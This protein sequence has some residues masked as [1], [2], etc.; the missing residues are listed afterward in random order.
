MLLLFSLHQPMFAGPSVSQLLTDD[1]ILTEHTVLFE[2]ESGLSTSISRARI[3]F[4]Q[5]HDCQSGY[6]GFYDTFNED[7]GFAIAIGKP[8]GLNASLTYQAGITFLGEQKI[9][10]M[11]SI[12]IRFLSNKGQFAWFTGACNDQDVNCCVPVDCSNQT[13]TCLAS[14]GLSTQWFTL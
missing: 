9:E 2:Q 7:K 11:H 8:F 1:I 14:H 10:Q 12:L 6:A 13:G 3:H 5:S 4:L